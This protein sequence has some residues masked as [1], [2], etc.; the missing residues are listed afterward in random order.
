MSEPETTHPTTPE[1]GDPD[2]L[3]PGPATVPVHRAP[4]TPAALRRARPVTVLLGVLMLTVAGWVLIAQ[5][6]DV[7]VSPGIAVVTVMVG[8]GLLLIAGARRGHDPGR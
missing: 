6:T 1:A 7:R 5:L 3:G 4:S 2:R 8:A